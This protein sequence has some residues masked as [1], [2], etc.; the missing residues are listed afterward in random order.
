[1]AY[2][3][4]L[5]GTGALTAGELA[6]TLKQQQYEITQLRAENLLLKKKLLE[7]ASKGFKV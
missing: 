7:A 1:M 6:E 4:E 2:V 3:E 5:A